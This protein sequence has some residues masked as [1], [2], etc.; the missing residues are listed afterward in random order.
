MF[1][2]KCITSALLV[3]LASAACIPQ[4]PIS[5]PLREQVRR[6]LERR[7]RRRNIA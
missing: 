7:A 2:A 6:G 3:M 5:N 1:L 4:V